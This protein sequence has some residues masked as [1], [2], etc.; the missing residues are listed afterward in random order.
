MRLGQFRGRVCTLQLLAAKTKTPGLEASATLL[1]EAALYDW[2]HRW[3]VIQTLWL[4]LDALVIA[5]V[6][7]VFWKRRRTHTG[8]QYLLAH[9]L[10]L[11]VLAGTL[12]NWRPQP[13]PE[14]RVLVDSHVR[15]FAV[16]ERLNCVAGWGRLTRCQPQR[17]LLDD[18]A[19]VWPLA[20][21][22]SQ[23][24]SVARGAELKLGMYDGRVYRISYSE[25]PAEE[26]QKCGYRQNPLA[27]RTDVIWLCGDGLRI[28]DHGRDP[29]A[30]LRT[31]V[32]QGPLPP[33]PYRWTEQAYLEV[34]AWHNRLFSVVLLGMGVL[35]VHFLL[36]KRMSSGSPKR[37]KVLR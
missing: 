29:L 9:V 14:E 4:M 37:S 10:V 23:P 6:L 34:R 13:L 28:I 5:A 11:T 7:Y 8:N 12:W 24:L 15:F 26:P 16:G 32:V 20:Y 27:R 22:A 3:L 18:K 19:Q 36:S 21:P 33:M 2:R 35:L 1:G 25:T 17:F 30:A 31:H